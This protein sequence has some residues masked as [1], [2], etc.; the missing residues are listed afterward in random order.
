ML[1]YYSGD[2]HG[3]GIQ[4]TRR[5]EPAQA[6][7]P[8]LCDE[9]AD[10]GRARRAPRHDAPGGDA[11]PGPSGGGEPR[12][13]LVARAREAALPQPR[14]ALRDLRTLDRQVRALAPARA[15]RPEATAGRRT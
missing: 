10:A 2:G 3:Q 13:H 1:A 12:R 4:G 7:R 11:A 6:P 8:A 15:A 5:P 9:R 14:A